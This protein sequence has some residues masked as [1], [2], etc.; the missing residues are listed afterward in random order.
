MPN[1]EPYK[2]TRWTLRFLKK[3][4]GCLS[5]EVTV[6][7]FQNAKEAKKRIGMPMEVFLEMNIQFH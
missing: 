4:A 6:P 7:T 1:S 3:L 5:S 2:L